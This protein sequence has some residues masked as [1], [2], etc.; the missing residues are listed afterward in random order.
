MRKRLDSRAA[1]KAQELFDRGEFLQKLDPEEVDEI[2]Q[3]LDRVK[4][5][6]LELEEITPE[7]FLIPTLAGRLAMLADLA[8]HEGWRIPDQ[9]ARARLQWPAI[10]DVSEPRENERETLSEAPTDTRHL[11]LRSPLW[12]CR[13]RGRR[14][15]LDKDREFVLNGKSLEGSHGARGVAR[16]HFEKPENFL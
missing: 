15:L 7:T 11:Q 9:R 16:R 6:E 8:R 2:R 14:A 12:R 4:S 5:A 3:A 10:V 1:W 13:G